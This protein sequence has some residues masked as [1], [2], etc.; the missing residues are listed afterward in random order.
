MAKIICGKTHSA[1]IRG[2]VA[3]RIKTDGIKAKLAVVLVGDNPASIVYINM[4]KKACEE[5]GLDFELKKLPES[6]TQAEVLA[7][8][9]EINNDA[10]ITGVLVQQPFPPQLN[11]DEIL[12]RLD[13]RKDVDCLNP[14]NVGLAATGQGKLLPCTPAGCIELLKR[15]GIEI[16]GKNS[17]IVGR[18]E[19]VGKPLA[20]MLLAENATVTICHSR[21]KNLAE[22]CRRADILVAALGRPKFITADMVKPNAI[23]IDVGVNRLEGK[24][25]CGDVDYDACEKTASHITPVPGGVGP[26]T[27]ATL[28]ENCVKAW[29]IQRG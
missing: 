15:E 6:A 22:E 11:K 23:I 25:I 20:L 14:H 13:P 2:E 7:L 18:S 10:E 24:K 12:S 17:V 27:V 8:I 3:A 19:I 29:E 5:V 16:C 26:M 9:D 1:A 28:M 4:K 21:T